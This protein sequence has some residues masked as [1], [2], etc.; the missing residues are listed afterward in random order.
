MA[1]TPTEC[2]YCRRGLEGSVVS[3]LPVHGSVCKESALFSSQ[4]SSH[5]G[6]AASPS[7][8]DIAVPIHQPL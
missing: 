2:M 1:A 4:A 5:V 3:M 7:N 6:S 8:G